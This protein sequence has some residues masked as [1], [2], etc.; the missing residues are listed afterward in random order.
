LSEPTSRLAALR[1]AASQPIDAASLAV[2]RMALGLCVMYD[3]SRKGHRIFNSN[4]GKAFSFGYEGFEWIPSAGAWGDLLQMVW[5]GAGVAVALGLLYRPAIVIVTLLT[6][7]GFLQAQEFYL[8]HYYLLILVCILMC[9]VPAHR[10]WSLDAWLMP[11][12]LKPAPLRAMHLWLL[13]GQTEIVLIFAGLVKI[14]ADWLQLEPLRSWLL[15]RHDETF[16]EPLWQ[17]DFGMAA[18]AYGVIVLHVLGAPLLLWKRTRLAVAIVYVAFHLSNHFTFEIGIFPWMTIGMTMLFFDP[19]WPRRWLARLPGR[20]G[21]TGAAPDAADVA[22]AAASGANGPAS[23]PRWTNAFLALSGLWLLS[24]VLI[25]LRHYAYEGSVAWTYEGHQFAW[26][27]KLVDR[28]SPGLIA[29][30]Y[31]P[32][33]QVL[34]VPPL[35]QMMTR[36]QYSNVTTR[37][38]MT[39]QLGPQLAE[40]VRTRLGVREVKVHVYMPVGYNNREAIPLINP[41]FDLSRGAPDAR[42]GD[43]LIRHNDKPLRR[44]EQFSSDYHFPDFP[45]LAVTMGL[46]RPGECNKLQ[47]DWIE[48]PVAPVNAA[49]SAGKAP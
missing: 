38:P 11:K 19:D 12:A 14:N 5:F 16:L 1:R 8:N 26:R 23:T 7:F 36:R 44:L 31:A 42:Q 17:T 46:P 35:R 40:K 32:E 30:A 15:T 28:W 39:R 41:R 33:R 47:D 18:A 2:F 4:D 43:W 29:V 13:K 37:P 9:F 20:L 6:S 49:G 10:A 27:M 34:L 21:R 3:A 22:D 25:P 45:D 24:Q 48:C